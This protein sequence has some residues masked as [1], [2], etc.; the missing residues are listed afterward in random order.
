MSGDADPNTGYVCYGEGRDFVVGGTSAVSP[1]WAGLTARL[2]QAL[3]VQTPGT[4]LGF[5]N[6]RLYAL[7]GGFNDVTDGNNGAYSAR[8]GW[9]A[10]PAVRASELHEVKSPLILQPG[11]AALTDG[12][13]AL[14]AIVANWST[15]R[16]SVHG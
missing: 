3:S 12:L 4:R 7:R 14:H 13:D 6:P 1:L 11:P 9:D 10:I 16:T 8:P 2:N 15:V 5:L